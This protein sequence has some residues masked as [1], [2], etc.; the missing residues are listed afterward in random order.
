MRLPCHIF[1]MLLTFSYLNSIII[2]CTNVNICDIGI[3]T[4][5]KNG[6]VMYI[7]FHVH[8]FVDEIAERAVSKLKNTMLNSNYPNPKMPVTNGTINE[9]IAKLDEWGVDAGVLLPIATKP[10]QQTSINNWAAQ[11]QLDSF[12]YDKASHKAKLYCYGTVHP[13]AEDIFEELER[14]KSLGL[15]GIK[16]HPDYQEFFADEDRMFPIYKKCAELN[17]PVIFHAGLDCLSMELIHCTPK[18]GANICS[19]VPELTFI[20]AHLGGNSCWD[21][22]EEYL[23]GRNVYLDTAFIAGALPD[24]QILR[25][26]KNHGADKILLASD[27]PWDS[28]ADEIDLINRLDLSDEEKDMIFYK[29]ALKLLTFA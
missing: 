13:N 12:N 28:T 4:Q 22:V 21:D 23:V 20:M 24:E 26:I 16:F 7:D 27:C 2:I 10:S 25:I 1:F 29:N 9:L 19:N 8:A 15:K 18:M 6:E 11:I 5:L 14:I 3:A 17:L